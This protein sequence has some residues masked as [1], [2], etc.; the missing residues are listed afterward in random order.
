M[1]LSPR[2]RRPGLTMAGQALLAFSTFPDADTARKIVRE[3]VEA[4]LVACGNIV[5]QI[6]SIYRWQGKLESSAEALAIFKLSSER[7]A[8]FESK[9]R[10]LHPYDVPEIVCLEISKG[11]PDYLHW[12]TE[13]CGP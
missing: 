10:S 5:P 9:L 12:V 8:D 7:Y 4:R 13:S 3:L 6:E 2:R 1:D 11:L